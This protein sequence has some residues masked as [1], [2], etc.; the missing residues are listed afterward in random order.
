MATMCMT[1]LWGKRKEWAK[2][3]CHVIIDIYLTHQVLINHVDTFSAIE[4]NSILLMVWRFLLQTQ[5]IIY[6]IQVH[7]LDYFC[8]RI[9]DF[10]KHNRCLYRENKIRTFIVS[11]LSVNRNWCVIMITKYTVEISPLKKHIPVRYTRRKA[12][13]IQGFLLFS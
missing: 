4:Q 9:I 12:N 2:Y 8:W 6:C 10:S 3:L 5:D 13:L 11:Y 1:N 7:F